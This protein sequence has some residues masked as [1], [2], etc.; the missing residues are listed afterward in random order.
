M[1]ERGSNLISVCVTP[2]MK[3]HFAVNGHM[4][5]KEIQIHEATVSSPNRIIVLVASICFHYSFYHIIGCDVDS[6]GS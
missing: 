5:I 4:F 6:Q 2:D 3:T 1:V